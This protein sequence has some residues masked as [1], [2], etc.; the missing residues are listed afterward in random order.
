MATIKKINVS[1]V[2]M[3]AVAP[4]NPLMGAV[5]YDT[6]NKLYK[7]YNGSAWVNLVRADLVSVS[8]TLP[9]GTTSVKSLPD[10]VAQVDSQILAIASAL[11]SIETDYAKTA[12]VNS[13]IATAKGEAIEAAG[14]AADGKITTALGSYSTTTAMNQAIATAKSEAISEAGTAADGKISAALAAYDTTTVSEGKIAAAKSEAIAAAKTETEGQVSAAKSELTGAIATA[15]S[16]A[17]AAAKTETESQIS[18]LGIADYAKTADVNSAISTAKSELQG[19]IDEKVATSGYEA[20]VASLEAGIAG[21][22]TGVTEAKAAAAQALVDAKAYTDGE[23]DKL[24]ASIAAIKTFSVQVVDELPET[25][26]EKVIYLVPAEDGSDNKAE[27]LWVNGGWELIG[28]THVSLAGYA[29]ESYVDGKASAAE[30]AAIA[31]AKTET[32]GQVS[33]AKA[34][35]KLVTDALDGRVA[36]NEGAISGIN[37][38]LESVATK[39]EVATAKSEAISEAGSAADTKISTALASYDTTAVSEGKIATAKSEAI[40][41]AKSETEGQIAAL[42]ISTYA[43]KTEVEAVDAKADANAQAI[44]TKADKVAKYSMTSQSVEANASFTLEAGKHYIFKS[45][46]SVNVIDVAV[47]GTEVYCEVVSGSDLITSVSDT[48]VA[49]VS[50]ACTVIIEDIAL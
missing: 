19:K 22:A 42:E 47:N 44:A 41:A 49:V 30:S 5:W 20:K 28:T 25:G 6:E 4:S 13:A 16:E 7:E 43:K 24:E 18:A 27:Y 15:K 29:T 36:A 8:T 26:E 39:S 21:N 32:E 37:T 11:D 38:T 45:A 2:F 23:V 48:L 10:Y 9:D 34:E 35:I 31:A 12:D 3:S 46:T 17:I 14:L 40:A 50:E 33:A 1:N